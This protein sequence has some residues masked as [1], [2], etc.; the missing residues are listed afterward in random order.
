M[1]TNLALSA[2][3]TAGNP[4]SIAS[5]TFIAFPVVA[6]IAWPSGSSARRMLA[7]YS[8]Q[9]GFL[10]AEAELQLRS[11]RRPGKAGRAPAG[12]RPDD[13]RLYAR[14]FLWRVRQ[15]CGRIRPPRASTFSARYATKKVTSSPQK[16]QD[17]GRCEVT[18]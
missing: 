16:R 3:R 18:S 1:T 10:F 14:L 2:W 11:A 17:A 13:R 4:W 6:C 5:A 9:F 15:F 8:G 7:V 12:A